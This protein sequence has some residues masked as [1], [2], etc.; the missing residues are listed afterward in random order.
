[1]R[2]RFGLADTL[3]ARGDTGAAIGHFQALLQLN[4]DD[5]Q[6]AR[7]RLLDRLLA[8]LLRANRDDET[9]TLLGGHDEASALWCYAGAMVEER[10]ATRTDTTSRCAAGQPPCAEVPDA[11]APAA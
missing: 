6:G 10:P 9:E 8:A 3:A 5:N 2:T 7:Y 1:M 11:A 4:P